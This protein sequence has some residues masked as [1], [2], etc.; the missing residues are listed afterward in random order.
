MTTEPVE[1]VSSILTMC[2]TRKGEERGYL[3][4]LC[5]DPH[6]VGWFQRH[7]SRLPE[8]V[9]VLVDHENLANYHGDFQSVVLHGLLQTADYAR[10]IINRLDPTTFEFHV[11]EWV[12][13]TPVGGREVMSGQ[14]HHPLLLGAGGNGAD[15]V[16][17]A[18][19]EQAGTA[20]RDSKNETGPTLE[21][22]TATWRAL[23]RSAG[24]PGVQ[25]G[26]GGE[27]P[28]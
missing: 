25:P 20:V 24:F 8:Q 15:C 16:E 11:H 9:R 27:Q 14:L 2:G 4:S 17:V 21:F 23:L 19:P 3:L 5:E 6:R 13:R 7:G 12:L 22:G 10:V 26:P 1:H 18:W 28:A